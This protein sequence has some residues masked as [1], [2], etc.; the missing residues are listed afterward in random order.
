MKLAYE[1]HPSRFLMNKTHRRYTNGPD[2]DLS[3]QPLLKLSD[4]GKYNASY[5]SKRFQAPVLIPLTSE[6]DGSASLKDS[7]QSHIHIRH[8]YMDCKSWISISHQVLRQNWFESSVQMSHWTK[9][10]ALF[11]E[12]RDL[13]RGI[14]YTDP[15]LFE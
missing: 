5:R 15:S 8:R 1:W 4:Y 14:P 10:Q 3:S 12:S 6:I 7:V 13:V 11:R 2:F 9:V